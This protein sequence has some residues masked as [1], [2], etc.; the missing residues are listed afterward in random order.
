[1]DKQLK[2][3]FI[4]IDVSKKTLDV[5]CDGGVF[6]AQFSNDEAGYP[7]LIDAIGQLSPSLVVLEATGGFETAAVGAMVSAQ[8]PVVVVNPRQARDFAKAIGLLAKTDQVDAL[9]LARFAQAVS[10]QL[11]PFKSEETRELEAVLTR[12]RQLV[13]MVT[14]EQNRKLMAPARIAKEI[15]QHVQWLR[16]RIKGADTDLDTAIKSSPVWQAKADLLACVPGIGPVTMVT[17]LAELPEL[18]TLDRRAICALVGVCPFNRDSG[19]FRGKRRIWGGRAS[20]RA[21]LYMATLVATR[22]NP[23]IKQFYQ[24]LLEGGKLKKVA[25]VACMRKLLVTLNAILKNNTTW[26]AIYLT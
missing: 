3:V 10:P 15:D 12:R 24:K 20:V 9:M 4:G 2:K 19:K 6:S 1:M 8:L 26:S 13:D 16:Q 17:L 21:T 25:L 5:A 11:R 14:A 7:K 18:G 23:V 22:H